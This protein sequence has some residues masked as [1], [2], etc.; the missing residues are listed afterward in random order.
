MIYQGDVGLYL[1]GEQVLVPE[2][3]IFITQPKVRQ[4]VQFGEQKFL[5]AIQILTDPDTLVQEIKQGNSQLKEMGNFQIL[6]ELI[7]HDESL[8]SFFDILFELC[9][10]NYEVKIIKNSIEFYIEEDDEKVCRGR[11]NSRNFEKF[12]TV[13]K[14][15]FIFVSNDKNS[16]DYNPANK[17]AQ[18]IAD[19]IKKGRAKAG[20]QKGSEKMSLY[21]TYVS[22]LS[23]GMQLD[24]NQLYNYTPFQ[25][26]DTFS[27]YWAKVQSDQFF[28]IQIMPF[29]NVSES[30]S[31]E[32]WT[33][34]FYG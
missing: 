10:P 32:E 29:S 30:D 22:I 31:P 3:G 2:C 13:L 5:T 1:S 18:E 7:K 26:Y 9:C 24:M 20:Q 23:V 15:L 4:I 14:E 27:R 28:K 8:K 25:L 19:K 21:G 16:P 34:N 33:R 17:L 6:L 11:I 12:T